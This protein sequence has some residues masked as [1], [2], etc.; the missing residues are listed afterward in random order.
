MGGLGLHAGCSSSSRPNGQMGLD[1]QAKSCLFSH[2]P[3]EA[4]LYVE[5]ERM[6]LEQQLPSQ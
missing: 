1:W 5:C 4:C 2:R 6:S 3:A